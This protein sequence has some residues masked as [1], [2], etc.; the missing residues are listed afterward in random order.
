[1]TKKFSY[2]VIVPRPFA[3]KG[4]WILTSR[5]FSQAVQ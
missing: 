2:L 1:M 4:R 5:Y 3:D